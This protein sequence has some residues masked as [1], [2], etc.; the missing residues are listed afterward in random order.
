M[1]VIGRDARTSRPPLVVVWQGHGFPVMDVHDVSNMALCHRWVG[2]MDIKPDLFPVPDPLFEL[3]YL[4]DCVLPRLGL[5]IGLI[6]NAWGA[7][8]VHWHA[9]LAPPGRAVVVGVV[10]DLLDDLQVVL[11]GMGDVVGIP[12]DEVVE[13]LGLGHRKP[14]RQL[15]VRSEELGVDSTKTT[16]QTINILSFIILWPSKWIDSSLPYPEH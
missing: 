13:R 9:E 2:V 12:T 16:F 14:T 5:A 10:G 4:S 3:R 11:D 7:V 1:E 15:G 6:F 8:L